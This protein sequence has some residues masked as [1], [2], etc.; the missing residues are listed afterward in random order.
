[1]AWSPLC[2]LYKVY[3]DTRSGSKCLD[4]GLGTCLITYQTLQGSLRELNYRF[5][6]NLLTTKIFSR[7]SVAVSAV[8]P[9]EMSS[10]FS[11][12]K[13]SVLP[14]FN[15]LGSLYYSFLALKMSMY[16]V[17]IGLLILV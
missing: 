15:H 7:I 9:M 2:V 4:V 3:L 8:T 13:R 16:S 12:L 11:S 10:E 6:R 1:M 5:F 14:R 17:C